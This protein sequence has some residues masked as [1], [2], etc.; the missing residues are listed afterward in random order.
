MAQSKANLENSSPRLGLILVCICYHA[1]KCLSLVAID[2]KL[3]KI[4]C[5]HWIGGG[6]RKIWIKFTTSLVLLYKWYDTDRKLG[7]PDHWNKRIQKHTYDLENPNPSNSSDMF[8]L[9]LSCCTDPMIYPII[10]FIAFQLCQLIKCKIRV[11]NKRIL[12]RGF[13]YLKIYIIKNGNL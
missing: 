10:I 13:V 3:L 7:N 2:L 12:L 4:K 1:L 11:E 9:C 6:L 5:R 8:L